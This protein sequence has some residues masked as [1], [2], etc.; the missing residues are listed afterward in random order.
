MSRWFRHFLPVVVDLET[1]GVDHTIHPTLEIACVALNWDGKQC[2]MDD[3][4]HAHIAPYE[5][6]VCDPK[7]LE[8]TGII[9]DHPFRYALE[10]SEMLASLH[11]W[12]KPKLKQYKCQKAML[13]GHNAHFDL[14]FLNQI[15]SRC[16]SKSSFH[17]FSVMDTVTLGMSFYGESVLARCAYKAGIHFDEKQ[18]HSALYDAKITA[19]LFCALVNRMRMV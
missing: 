17:A 4:Y 10:E 11:A 9:P 12:L 13:V 14:G 3:H 8:V 5:G 2:H 1:G 6:S 16:G 15:Y 7:A 18:A 19:A